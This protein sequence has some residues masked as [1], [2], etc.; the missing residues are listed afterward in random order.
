MSWVMVPVP[1]E[2]VDEV[3]GLL[4]AL[5]FR[6]DI[7]EFDVGAM[8]EHLLTLG[9]EAGHVMATVAS[10]VVDGR[11]VEPSDLAQELG[12]SVREL[13]GLVAEANDVTVRKFGGNIVYV[14][15]EKD[16]DDPD[17]SVTK[18]QMTPGYAHMVVEQARVLGIGR[19]KPS[20]S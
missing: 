15:R 20:G 10:A 13:F 18:L 1:E 9:P 4:F 5:R 11:G 2:L 12:V 16:P 3:Q 7:P 8:G 17:V 14:V 19:A 6:S